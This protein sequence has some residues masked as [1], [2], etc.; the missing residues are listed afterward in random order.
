MRAGG[1][2]SVDAIAKNRVIGSVLMRLT[3][4]SSARSAIVGG[5]IASNVTS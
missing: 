2:I 5:K 3:S 1:P 4:V